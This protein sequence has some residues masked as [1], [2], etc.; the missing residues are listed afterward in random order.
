MEIPENL[1]STIFA[2]AWAELYKI[3]SERLDQP[4]VDLMESVFNSVVADAQKEPKHA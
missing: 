1:P 3:F 2:Q 4:N